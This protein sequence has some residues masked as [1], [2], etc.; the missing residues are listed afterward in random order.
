MQ[1]GRISLNPF[2]M[3]NH[4][5]LSYSRR[6]Q[7]WSHTVSHGQLLL[8]STNGSEH[9]TH[10]TQVD[11]LFKNVGMISI[12]TLFDGLT[13]ISVSLDELVA[14]GPA[15][16]AR[17][18]QGRKCFRLEGDDCRGSIIASVVAWSEEDAEYYD[19]SKLLS[20]TWAGTTRWG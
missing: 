9:G 17:S 7:L 18:S 3:T 2:P 20:G 8:R 6:F 13:V 15:V 5:I 19:E 12:P 10:T 1:G 14:D 11:V 16:T 4:T